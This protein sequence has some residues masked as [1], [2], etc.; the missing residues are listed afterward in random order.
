MCYRRIYHGTDG[1]SITYFNARSSLIT[2]NKSVIDK[3][4]VDP[5]FSIWTIII[6]QCCLSVNSKVSK[7]IVTE[8]ITMIID[9][10]R[11]I[12]P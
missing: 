11:P 9:R 3:Y 1:M 5:V 10:S 6:V 2:P 12:N 4:I 8:N 7:D